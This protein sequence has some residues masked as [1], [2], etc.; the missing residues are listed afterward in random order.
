MENI[1]KH[2]RGQPACLGVI[3]TAMIGIDQGSFPG[4]CMYLAMSK[5]VVF[6]FQRQ[7]FD[8]RSMGDPAQGQY[9]CS[10][11]HGIQFSG[12]IGIAGCDLASQGLV[13]RGQAFYRVG[14]PA[15]FQAQAVVQ[16]Q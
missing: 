10:A 15:M 16:V 13:S 11:G 1:M 8:Y 2:I 12:Q 6:L 5:C 7:A 14:N 4:E 9:R 3:A